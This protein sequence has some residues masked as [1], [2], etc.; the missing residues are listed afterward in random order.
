MRSV[1]S[2]SGSPSRYS[3]T[4]WYARSDAT[5]GYWVLELGEL[6]GMKKTDVE[7]VKSFL[8]RVD[9]KYRASYGLNVESHPRPHSLC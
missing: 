8:S 3:R 4:G 5:A 6:A 1:P 7:T 9:D 2:H